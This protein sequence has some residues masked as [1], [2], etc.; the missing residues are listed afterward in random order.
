MV[1]FKAQRYYAEKISEKKHS[2]SLMGTVIIYIYI[3]LVYL[4]KS[5]FSALNGTNCFHEKSELE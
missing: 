5:V 3:Y 4:F 2:I 1:F